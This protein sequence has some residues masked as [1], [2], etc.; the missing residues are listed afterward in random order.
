[1]DKSLARL[2]SGLV[3]ADDPTDHAADPP[4]GRCTTPDG[5]AIATYDFGGSGPDLLMVHATG[6]CANVLGPIAR[7]LTDHYHCWAI[8]L[9]GHGRSGRPSDD[10]FAWTGFATDV[11]T[12]VDHLGLERPLGFGHSCGGASLLLAE[13][14]RP[15]TFAS[16][17]GFE[18]V[19]FPNDPVPPALGGNPLSA[20]ALRRRDTFPSRTDAMA[21]FSSKP[22]LADLDPA[23]LSAYVE[24]GFELVPTIDGGDG[25]L[26]RLRCRKED[27]ALVYANGAS[28]GAFGALDRVQCHV[29]LVCGERTDAFG[30]DFLEADAERLRSATVEVMPDTGHFGP[31]QYPRRTAAS[32]LRAFDPDGGTPHL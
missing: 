32:I 13:E 3:T 31:L 2:P 20:G 8:D 12:A 25:R 17:Y 19:V 30:L 9:R 5:V 10:D 4:T 16:L 26:I 27:E 23:V 11:L 6:F 21:N 7:A 1:M 22:P 15:G 18:P 28:H 24:D 29:T 14:R